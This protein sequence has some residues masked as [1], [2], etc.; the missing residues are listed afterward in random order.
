MLERGP[1]TPE[2]EAHVASC[3]ACGVVAADGGAL[4][5]L[6]SI[7]APSTE[8]PDNLF[9]RVQAGLD[10]PR[11]D[12]W[13]SLSTRAR[14]GI[15]LGFG[16]LAVLV[17]VLVLPR[18]DLGI[19]P[20]ARLAME[21]GVLTLAALAAGWTVLWPMHRAPLR[22]GVRLLLA[23]I[24]LLLPVAMTVLPMAHAGHSAS[25][26]GAG[27]DLARRAIACFIYG[28]VWTAPLLVSLRLLDRMPQRLTVLA[29]AGAAG[30]AATL[31]L[32]LHCPIT[33][34]VHLLA[35]HATIGLVMAAGLMLHWWRGSRR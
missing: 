17:N 9:A 7:G 22:D 14:T 11:L 28:I 33:H 19:Y 2:A 30:V 23:G 15:A 21:L 29:A 20:A 26:V 1:L 35:G 13:R 16:A 27:D 6:L 32:L 18:V 24:G 12:R 34:P 10:E 8:L 25:V 3:P 5:R 31:A 4:A